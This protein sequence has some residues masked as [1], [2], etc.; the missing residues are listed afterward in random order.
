MLRNFWIPSCSAGGKTAVERE[1][2]LEQMSPAERQF[3]TKSVEDIAA[4]EHVNERFGA[5]SESTF[6]ENEPPTAG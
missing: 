6:G 4:D 5:V 2:E 1:A 3:S